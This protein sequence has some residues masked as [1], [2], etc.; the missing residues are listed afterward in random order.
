MLER[1]SRFHVGVRA[2]LLALACTALAPAAARAE[3]GT[4]SW[5]SDLSVTASGRSYSASDYV[6]A[7]KTLPLGTRVRVENLRNGKSAVVR[8][9][10]RGPYISGRIIDV[11]TGVA[12]DLGFYG[13]GLTPARVTV[14]GRGDD[15]E[16]SQA[17]K[18]VQA[19]R[20]VSDDDETPRKSAKTKSVKA[21]A[22]RVAAASDE[23]RPAPRAKRRKAARDDG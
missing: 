4:M 15:D 16:G 12:G 6:A 17:K 13:Q 14:L 10:D 3:T 18:K 19:K 22:V 8:I 21:K 2:A 9:V 7:H 23:D 5:Y 1:Q 20:T 11:T